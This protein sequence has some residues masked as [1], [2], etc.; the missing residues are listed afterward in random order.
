MTNHLNTGQAHVCKKKSNPDTEQV[1]ELDTVPK[2]CNAIYIT[3][4]IKANVT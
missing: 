2:Y 3:E 1:S 4:E